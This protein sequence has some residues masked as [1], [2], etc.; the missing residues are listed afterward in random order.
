MA[1]EIYAARLGP[2]S[3]KAAALTINRANLALIRRDPDTART[4]GLHALSML[5]KDSNSRDIANS[6]VGATYSFDERPAE[7]LPYLRRA[8]ESREATL[9]A[10]HPFVL[11]SRIELATALRRIGAPEDFQEASTQLARARAYLS[12][13]KSE[14]IRIRLNLEQGLLDL[15]MGHQESALRYCKLALKET[16]NDSY[17]QAARA[18]VA[19]T[20]G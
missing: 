4:L 3:H 7:A 10:E 20:E 17:L 6:I 19:E 18:C 9:G 5:E 12:T 15:E 8:L 11:A 1:T 2:T 14:S 13:Q 16:T